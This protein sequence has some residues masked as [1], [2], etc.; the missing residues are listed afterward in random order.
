[1]SVFGGYKTVS[2]F[3]GDVGITDM[4]VDHNDDYM[5]VYPV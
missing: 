2:V 3:G 4:I 1:M 5:Y